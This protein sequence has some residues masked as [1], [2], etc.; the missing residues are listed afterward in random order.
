MNESDL[1]KYKI[2]DTINQ[3][4][5]KKI[6]ITNLRYGIGA[7]LNDRHVVT[8][9]YL[10]V[11]CGCRLQEDKNEKIVGKYDMYKMSDEELNKIKDVY[12]PINSLEDLAESRYKYFCHYIINPNYMSPEQAEIFQYILSVLTDSCFQIPLEER[13][14]IETELLE[15]APITFEK[16]L[17]FRDK[18]ITENVKEKIINYSKRL[19]Y[20]QLNSFLGYDIRGDEEMKITDIQV[21]IL[22]DNYTKALVNLTIDDSIVITN[23]SLKESKEGNLYIT[24]P[25][26]KSIDKTAEKDS[27]GNYPTKYVDSVYPKNADTRNQLQNLII[28]KYNQMIE[29]ENS[30]SMEE[31]IEPE[32]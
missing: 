21:R 1:K 14:K 24:M 29:K 16:I 26:R 30:K 8:N 3:Y 22:K 25:Q 4:N 11:P 5:N 23:I 15:N 17:E 32:M 12:L 19:T 7:T 9:L 13:N 18:Y 2:P 6:D 20:E 28:E 31:D 27:S 10:G